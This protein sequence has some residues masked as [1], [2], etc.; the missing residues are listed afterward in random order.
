MKKKQK[1]DMYIA[2]FLIFIGVI[3]LLMP[4]LGVTNLKWLSVG[5]FSLYTVLNIIQFLLTKESKDYEGIHTAIAS[6]IVLIASII[7]NPQNSPRTLAMLLMIWI[8]LMSLTKLKKADYYHDRKDRMWKY[9][10]LNLGLFILSGILTSI[11]LAY[12]NEV[13]IIILGFFMLI[14]GILELFEPITKTLIA[15]S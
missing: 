8:V 3:L 12:S 11:N 2:L 7:F 14:H 10:A 6:L 4:I 1:I 9:S 5:I 13:Q 15:H